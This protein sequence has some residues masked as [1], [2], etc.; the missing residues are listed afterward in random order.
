MPPRASSRTIARSVSGSGTSETRGKG[1]LLG[2]DGP[3]RGSVADVTPSSVGAIA[4][5][6]SVLAISCSARSR[7]ILRMVADA[8]APSVGL[9]AH[10]NPSDFPRHPLR[11]TMT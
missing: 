1:A 5:R 4:R 3:R 6:P 8:T 9:M 11:R 10:M 7:S 2:T